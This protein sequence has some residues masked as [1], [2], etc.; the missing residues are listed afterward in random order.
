[1]LKNYSRKK[2]K[3]ILVADYKSAH[4]TFTTFAIEFTGIL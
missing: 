3:R 1:M 4:T 2:Q